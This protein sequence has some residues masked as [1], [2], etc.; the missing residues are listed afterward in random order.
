MIAFASRLALCAAILALPAAFAQTAPAAAPTGALSKQTMSRLLLN[1]A[2]RI[3]NRVVAVGDR[4][5]VVFSDSNGESWER[6]QTPAN[7]PMLT[8][9]YFVDAKNG[10]IVGH[11]SIILKSTDE[12]KTWTQ[13]F[14]AA[15][16]QKPFMD[17]LFIDANTGFAVGAYGAFYETRDAGKTWNPRK[18]MKAI[19]AAPKRGG[20]DGKADD[21]GKSADE[22]KHLNAILKLADGKLFIVGEAGTLLRSD[23]SGKTWVPLPSPYKGSFFGA[24]QATDGSV[25]IYGLR[26]K[27][28][29]SD[30][31]LRDWKLVDN[32]SLASLMGSTRLPDGAIVL[33][34]LSGTVL[35]SRDNGRSFVPL[36]T[37]STKAYAA[38]LLGAPNALLL[39]GE[40]GARDVVLPSAPK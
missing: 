38:P 10:W 25:L 23:D 34:G 28:Y 11:D 16:E 18:I 30:A 12:G 2:A 13:A 21:I 14:S 20:G 33:A 5:Y 35:V 7:V 26:G 19:A 31:S 36:P 39:L 1:D 15:S 24:I 3:G 4:G 37:G 6:A 22:D 9:V 8:S 27:I 40:A 29:R 17:I 32:K